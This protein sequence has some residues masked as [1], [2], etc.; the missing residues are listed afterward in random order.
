MNKILLWIVL[1][2]AQPV[3]A[4]KLNVNTVEEILFKTKTSV[5]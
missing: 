4:Q 2:A 3:G 5:V 1:A